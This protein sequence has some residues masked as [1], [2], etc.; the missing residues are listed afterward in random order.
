MG[1]G[2]AVDAN[3]GEIEPVVG[4]ENL[5]IAF[6]GRADS[7]ARCSYCKTVEKF[8][9]RDH[10]SSLGVITDSRRWPFRRPSVAG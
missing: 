10:I 4:T 8:T 7:E 9:S 1:I 5:G 6:G 2:A 3:D